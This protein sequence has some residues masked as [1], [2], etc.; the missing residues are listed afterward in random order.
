[1]SYNKNSKA[2]REIWGRKRKG[3]KANFNLN[4]SCF[5]FFLVSEYST[6]FD[7]LDEVSGATPF[8]VK[9]YAKPKHDT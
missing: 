1:M 7:A 6:S 2:L 9:K 4:F 3:K 5:N 8:A